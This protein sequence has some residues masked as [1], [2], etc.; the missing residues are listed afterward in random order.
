[1]NAVTAPAMSG[2]TSCTSAIAVFATVRTTTAG[3]GR[4]PMRPGPEAPR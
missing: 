3:A 2:N 1:M 4:T